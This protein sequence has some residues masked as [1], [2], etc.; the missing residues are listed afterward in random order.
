MSGRR[1]REASALRARGVSI[2]RACGD[3]GVRVAYVL[4][5]SLDPGAAVTHWSGTA[6]AAWCCLI[7]FLRANV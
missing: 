3:R 4:Y 2:R 1:A 6:A 5:H 7:E